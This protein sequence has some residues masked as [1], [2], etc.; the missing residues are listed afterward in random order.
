[1]PTKQP[2]EGKASVI[3]WKYFFGGSGGKNFDRYYKAEIN[4]HRV[5]KHASNRG[6][7]YSI[8]NVDE[9]KEKYKSESE[10]IIAIAKIKLNTHV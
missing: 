3:E 10:L 7:E 4:G 5:E 1:M 9:A 8:G 6:V 2:E